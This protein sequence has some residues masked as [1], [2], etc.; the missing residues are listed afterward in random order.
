MGA[1]D[2]EPTP[3]DVLWERLARPPLDTPAALFLLGHWPLRFVAGQ[4]LYLLA[5]MAELL[6]WHGWRSWAERLSRAQ[7]SEKGKAP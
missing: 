4:M 5:P 2:P 1:A 7:G 6:G 3:E